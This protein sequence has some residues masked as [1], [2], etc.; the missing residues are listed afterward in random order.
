MG[1]NAQM[2]DEHA[3]KSQEICIP[4]AK[5]TRVPSTCVLLLTPQILT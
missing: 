5:N 3:Q 2:F 1:V 4:D